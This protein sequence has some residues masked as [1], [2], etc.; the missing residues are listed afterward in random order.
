MSDTSRRDVLAGAAGLAA[1]SA[2]SL[3]EPVLAQ[4]EPLRIEPSANYREFLRLTTALNR[5]HRIDAGYPSDATHTL[6]QEMQALLK[7]MTSRAPQTPTD[8]LDYAAVMLHYNACW[9]DGTE[10]PCAT[11]NEA[12]EWCGT[13]GHAANRLAWAVLSLAAGRTGPAPRGNWKPRRCEDP[14]L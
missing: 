9:F 3:P 1:G 10:C 11:L 7:V 4:A 12:D 14:D 5:R 6:W 8:L 13:P 2:L